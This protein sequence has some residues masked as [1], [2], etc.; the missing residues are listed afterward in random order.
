MISI[1]EVPTCIG[2]SHTDK[3]VDGMCSVRPGGSRYFLC[4]TCIDGLKLVADAMRDEIERQT[5]IA[6]APQ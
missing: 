5:V 6:G 3:E 1:P 4:F 2:C